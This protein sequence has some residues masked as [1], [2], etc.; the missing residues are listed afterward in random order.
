MVTTLKDGD[1]LENISSI[2]PPKNTGVETSSSN[3][4]A[5][6]SR[7]RKIPKKKLINIGIPPIRATSWVWNFYTPI[8]ASCLNKNIVLG[9]NTIIR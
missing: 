4:A 3:N 1:T 9:G 7:Y 6:L 8:K 5:S 2:N